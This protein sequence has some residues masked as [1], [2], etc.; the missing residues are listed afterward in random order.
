MS[1]LFSHVVVMIV[2][3]ATFASCLRNN[4]DSD[5]TYYTDTAI[6]SFTLGTL[7]QIHHTKA[8]DG[9]TDST[10]TSTFSA[11]TY[12]FDIDQQSCTIS[13][14]DSLPVGTDTKH[15]LATIKSM[16]GGTILLVLKSLEGKDSIA[17]YSSNDSIDFSSP[18]HIRVVNMKGTARRD[19]TV[20]LNVHREEENQFSWKASA[21][22]GYDGLEKRRLVNL[23]GRVW[24]TGF[25]GGS[26]NAFGNSGSSWD[27]VD[28][29]TGLLRNDSVIGAT[30]KYRYGIIDGKLMRSPANGGT[31]TE[32]K[33]DEDASLLPDK[34]VSFIAAPMTVDPSLYNLLIIG[35][36]NG[37][38]VCWS[39]IED[40]ADASQVWTYYN[41]DGYNR[42]P[43]PYLE[44]MKAV[45]Y[46]GNIIATGGSFSSVYTSP[47]WGLT[48][49]KNSLFALPAGFGR[50]AAAFGMAVDGN[51]ILYISRDGSDQVWSGRLSQL[52][53]DA[54]QRVFTRSR[55]RK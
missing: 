24:L 28:F 41:E 2:S 18:V 19:Y 4:D 14:A 51:N 25:H 33:L 34:S 8:K 38:T 9:V 37:K 29:S 32:E 39:K 7:K 36:R 31:W 12:A 54:G 3:L 10:Y 26:L 1:K 43:L 17:Y 21:I 48:W 15:V 40:D 22:R 44:N 35:N 45:L 30:A 6:T 20:S 27:E 13:N 42:K 55:S 16:N 46:G 50:T 5:T 47:D 23:D 49:N 11:S 52:G 53:W